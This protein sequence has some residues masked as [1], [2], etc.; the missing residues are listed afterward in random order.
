MALLILIPLLGIALLIATY[1][2]FFSRKKSF[3]SMAMVAH[4]MPRL[5][6]PNLTKDSS[7]SIVGTDVPG[8]FNRWYPWKKILERWSH[9]DKI[10]V[11][12]LLIKPNA[13]TIEKMMELLNKNGANFSVRTIPSNY[14]TEDDDLK[15]L[16]DESEEHHFAIFQNPKQLWI[17]GSHKRNDIYAFNCEFVS[18][19]KAKDDPRGRLY[20]RAF[21]ILWK[22]G[23]PLRN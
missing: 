4:T 21:E 12:Y 16:I 2:T 8:L 14:T 18:P 10:P 13:R 19:S 5:A 17:E 22:E 11:R 7:V 15:S 20:E 9:F 6:K 1:E 23:T 3:H